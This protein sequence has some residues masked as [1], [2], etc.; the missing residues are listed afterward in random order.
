MT[1]KELEARLRAL[2]DLDALLQFER[3]TVKAAIER[4]RKKAQ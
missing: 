1:D 3:E 4:L 2:L